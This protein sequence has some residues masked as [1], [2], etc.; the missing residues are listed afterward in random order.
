MKTESTEFGSSWSDQELRQADEYLNS[1]SRTRDQLTKDLSR[2]AEFFVPNHRLDPESKKT[3][4]KKLKFYNQTSYAHSVLLRQEFLLKLLSA[5][6]GY[7]VAVS[8]KNPILVYLSA[9]YLLEL[10]AISNTL[11]EALKDAKST[12][13]RDWQGRAGKFLLALCRGRYSSSDKKVTDFLRNAGVS[14]AA[15]E[16]FNITKAIAQLA[17]DDRFSNAV[18][19]YEFFSNICH[20]NGSSHQLFYQSMRLTDK[21]LLPSGQV[22]VT[23]GPSDAVTLHYP[24]RAACRSSVVQTAQLALACTLWAEEILKAL[25]NLPFT[26]ET[27]PF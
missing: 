14:A 17:A 5:V 13:L 25:P 12:D 8:N 16:P 23:A 4:A 19:D 22:M 18:N 26:D 20:H 6:D 9:R 27:V 24:S 1:L 15:V 10:L 2:P 21:V 7:I 3:I 11:A